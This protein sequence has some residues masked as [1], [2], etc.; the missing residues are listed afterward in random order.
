MTIICVTKIL[1]T[2]T[3]NIISGESKMNLLH[4]TVLAVYFGEPHFKATFDSQTKRNFSSSSPSF[5]L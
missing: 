2:I 3:T 1:M 5:S 4:H